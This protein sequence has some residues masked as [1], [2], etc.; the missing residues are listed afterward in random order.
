LR[1]FDHVVVGAGSAGCVLANRLSAD[2]TTSVL[3]LEAGG[4]DTDP[5]I[6]VPRGFAELLGDPAGV[7]HYPTRAIA[8]ARQPEVWVRGRTLGGSSSVNGMV[9]NRGQAADY[10]ALA[11]L[12]N[13][14]WGWDDMLPVFRTIEDHPLGASATRGT[15][16]PLRV[17]TTAGGDPL[18]E[19]VITAGTRLGWRY[20]QDLNESDDERLGYATA[21]IRD[22]RR[23]SAAAA[24]LHPVRGRDNLAVDVHALV[25]QVVVESDRAVGV[26]GRRNGHAFR[27]RARREVILS[28]G[29]VATPKILQLSGIGPA[30][31][32]RAA[33]VD[34]VLDSPN[35]GRRMREHR[36][37]LLQ[38]RLADNLGHNALLGHETGQRAAAAQYAATRTG[39]LAAPP[40]DV[41]GFFRSRPGLPR[42]DA[43]FQIA[44]FSV[45][46]PEP[47][48]PLTV[49]REPGM[50]CVAYALRPDSE[51][52]VRITSKDPDAPLDIDPNY[53]ATEHDRSTAVAVLRGARRLFDTPPLANRIERETVPGPGVRSDEE[54]LAAG[55]T[56]GSAGYHAVGTCAMGPGDDDVVDPFLRVRGVANLRVVDA[57]VLPRL[58]S[59][60]LN[61]PVSALAWRAAGLILED[62]DVASV[63]PWS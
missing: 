15:G 48:R 57:S 51:G 5:R 28:A 43:Q 37:F 12:G 3:L 2:P 50:M 62:R 49:E 58:V 24:F 35:V 6:S 10:D 27:A 4:A 26:V 32:L 40:F 44:S 45:L 21:T 20:A 29:A 30:D 55:L 52:S 59:G 19:D 1:V 60:N 47:G 61:A 33:G 23:V 8:P 18:L 9:Y 11:R 46:P 7:W 38:F 22:G 17:S 42:P 36:V 63:R 16:G 13:P 56:T 14:G 25:D 34:I 31:V 53:F 54:I 39:P 41:V